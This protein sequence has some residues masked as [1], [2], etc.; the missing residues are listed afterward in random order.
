MFMKKHGVEK[1]MMNMFFMLAVEFSFRIYDFCTHFSRSICSAIT[2]RQSHKIIASSFISRTK[3][4]KMQRERT[5]TSSVC[6]PEEFGLIELPLPS[7]HDGGL[8]SLPWNF[9][10]FSSSHFWI[11]QIV[12][13]RF[14]D[15]DMKFEEINLSF[16]WGKYT[17]RN[18]KSLCLIAYFSAFKWEI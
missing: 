15:E 17:L 8:M 16:L 7:R 1:D 4:K 5:R 11:E 13:G 9:S 2:C 3:K 14:S 12:L 18:S 6:C 10:S